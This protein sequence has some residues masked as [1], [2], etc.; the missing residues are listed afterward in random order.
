MLMLKK[1]YIARYLHTF[2]ATRKAAL[3]DFDLSLAGCFRFLYRAY[4]E[5]NFRALFRDLSRWATAA[6]SMSSRQ[7]TG[8]LADT[9]VKSRY[10][11]E[12]CRKT[13]YF[14]AP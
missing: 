7:M 1:T 13:L 12:R 9:F 3:S 5:L 10:F 14:H 2:A 11:E 4:I 8:A 6:P